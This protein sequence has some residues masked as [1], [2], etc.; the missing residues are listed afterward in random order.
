MIF[1][2]NRCLFIHATERS[3]VALHWIR[4]RFQYTQCTMLACIVSYIY[5]ETD[6]PYPGFVMWHGIP[7]DSVIRVSSL[8]TGPLITLVLVR[9]RIMLYSNNGICVNVAR[10]DS[11]MVQ[12][13]GAA[14]DLVGN[15]TTDSFADEINSIR[16]PCVNCGITSTSI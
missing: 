3:E 6:R 12:A 16:H 4:H 9:L 8:Y 10:R 15:F 13:S 14:E 7:P 1:Q 11:C 2:Y 5:I